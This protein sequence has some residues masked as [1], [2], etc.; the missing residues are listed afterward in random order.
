MYISQFFLIKS[1]PVSGNVLFESQKLGLKGLP[2]NLLHEKAKACNCNELTACLLSNCHYLH[3]R[4][5][6][7]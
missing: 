4:S 5:L 1:N 7:H 2:S 3:L 6:V